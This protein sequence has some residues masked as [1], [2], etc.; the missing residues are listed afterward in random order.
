[1]SWNLYAQQILDKNLYKVRAYG[2]EKLKIR[3]FTDLASV[4]PGGELKLAIHFDLSSPW[5]TYS[6]K[7]SKSHLPTSIK[8]TLPDGITILSTHWPKSDKNEIYQEDFLVTYI[9]KTN[10]Q[11][12]DFSINGSIRWQCCNGFICTTNE[13]QVTIPIK[14]G[15]TIK[16]KQFNLLNK[17]ENLN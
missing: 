17:I 8:L 15:K 11:K 4:T 12:S 5:Y 6:H 16:S 3:A 7:E 14:I 1:M 2:D 10:N 9:L 13:I